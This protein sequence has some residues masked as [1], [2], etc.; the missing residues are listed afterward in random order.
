MDPVLERIERL[1][2]QINELRVMLDALLV[3]ASTKEFYST[4]ELATLL[5]KAEFTVREWCRHG[6]IRALK[7]SSGRGKHPA[8]VIPHAEFLRLQREGLLPIARVF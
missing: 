2:T 4:A 8:W 5:G 1:S 6:R 7:Q 3:R